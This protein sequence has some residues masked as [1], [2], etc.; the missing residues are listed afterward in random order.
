MT[1]SEQ[2]WYGLFKPSKYKE[3][4][5]L[6]GKRSALYVAVIVLVLGLVT[7]AVPTAAIIAGFGG[8]DKLFSETMAPMSYDGEKLSI[9]RPFEINVGGTI[10]KI[11]TTYYTVPDKDIERDGTY[12]A[13]GS[14][15]VRMATIIGGELWMD[16]IIPLN[17]VL[18][19]GFSNDSLVELIPAIYIAIIISY[20][21]MSLLFFLKYGAYAMIMTL[22]INPMNKQFEIGLSI[23]EV[24]M[25]CFYGMSLG[26]II[27]NFNIAMGLFSP[28]IVSMVTVFVS[29]NFMTSAILSM[30]KGNHV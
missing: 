25:V 28:T 1:F 4:L 7:F 16:H 10:I 2:V 22:F 26:M 12:V 29:I 6:G 18:G 17:Q 11:D 30:R 27:T 21:I 13:L 15:N 14:K 8:M 9:E 3:L 19:A 5:N 20:L 23:G 24:F